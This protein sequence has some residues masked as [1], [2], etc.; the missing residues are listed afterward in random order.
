M[1]SSVDTL[2]RATELAFSEHYLIVTLEDARILQV[3]LVWYPALY[4]ATPDSRTRFQWIGGGL[5]I[6]WPELDLQ[7]SIHG[8][9]HGL[10][11]PK[12]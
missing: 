6:D 10:T 9:L 1:T 7:L 11:R 2:I 12:A 8:F 5:G 4:H 3:P